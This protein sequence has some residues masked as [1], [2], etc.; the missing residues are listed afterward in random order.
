CSM[1]PTKGQITAGRKL[2][3]F[4]L[5]QVMVS[6]IL[7]TY[8]RSLPEADPSVP[9]TYTPPKEP[10]EGSL[11]KRRSSR[12]TILLWTWP[13]G[14]RVPIENCFEVLGIP[15]CQFTVDRSWYPKADA[16]LVHHYDVYL[17]AQKLPL[18]PRSP[19]QRWVWYSPEP[20]S[21]HPVPAFMD[22]LF[23]L[24]M[25]YRRDSDIYAPYGWLEMLPGPQEVTIPPKSK[26]VAWVVSN[27]KPD[28]VQGRVRYYEELRKHIQV[29][30]YGRG[31]RPL[32]GNQLLPTLSHYKFYLAFENSQ[33]EDYI[34]EKVWRNAFHSGAVPVVLGPPRKNYESHIP[35]DSFIHVDDFLSPQELAAFL[36]ALD[37]NATR[38]AS[39]FRWR[40]QMKSVHYKSWGY[41]FC[42]AC[43][44]LQQS[45]KTMYQTVPQLSK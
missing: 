17:D 42:K 34:S 3:A 30:V 11:V 6:A 10:L 2:L 39:Y 35:P 40:S 20:P 41:Q 1:E 44:A 24:T 26:L 18:D 14:I 7:L 12:L 16:V 4:F 13:Y 22:N 21:K 33:H 27:W 36:H 25:S 43:R 31:H 28:Y 45:P 15:D 9:P 5:L 38:Y 23:N 32:P 29:D 19:I 8:L 37:K